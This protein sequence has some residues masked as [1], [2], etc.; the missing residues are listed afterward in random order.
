M[1]TKSQTAVKVIA[2]FMLLAMLGLNACTNGSTDEKKADQ[3]APAVV[4][5]LKKSPDSIGV[6]SPGDTGKGKID[7]S[8]RGTLVP[9]Q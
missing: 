1:S 8:G 2:I 7:T 9:H 5:T 3:A 6:K 4:D